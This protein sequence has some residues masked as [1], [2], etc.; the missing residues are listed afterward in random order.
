MQN[1][2]TNICNA[3]IYM[4]LKLHSFCPCC[5]YTEDK[6]NLFNANFNDLIKK[7]KY[8]SFNGF[9]KSYNL[10]KLVLSW[11]LKNKR[12]NR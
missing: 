7:I 3:Y 12:K 6:I 10:L 5:G 2:E 11:E 8:V 1:A 9:Y 4:I